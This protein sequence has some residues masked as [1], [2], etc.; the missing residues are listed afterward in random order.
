M[1]TSAIAQALS[2]YFEVDA[3]QIESNL[4][5]DTKIILHDVRLV[6]Q[7]SSIPKNT[8]GTSTKICVTGIVSEVAFTWSWSISGGRSWVKDAILTIKGCSVNVQLTQEVCVSV[9]EDQQEGNEKGFDDDDWSKLHSEADNGTSKDIKKHGGMYAYLQNQMEMIL[10]AL[11]LVIDDYEMTVEMPSP[12]LATGIATCDRQSAQGNSI[13]SDALPTTVDA[14]KNDDDT[15]SIVIGGRKIEIITHGRFYDHEEN[16]NLKEEISIQSFFVNIVETIQDKHGDDTTTPKKK[17]YPLLDPFSYGIESTRTHGKRFSGIGRG[18]VVKGGERFESIL[19]PNQMLSFHLAR[20]QIEAFGKLSG[21][22]L[23][24]RKDTTEEQENKKHESKRGKAHESNIK[25]ADT[26]KN[27]AELGDVSSFYFPIDSVSVDTMGYTVAVTGVSVH[28]MADGADL[29]AKADYFH[30]TEALSEHKPC[31]ASVTCSNISG[32]V[33]PS[34]Q[35]TIGSVSKVNI[36]HVFKLREKMENVKIL[37]IGEVWT[38]QIDSLYGSLPETVEDMSSAQTLETI[39]KNNLNVSDTGS[40]MDTSNGWVAPFPI[41]CKCN[42][43]HLVKGDDEDT[44]M[45]VGNIEILMNPEADRSGTGLAISLESMESKLA[46]V[47]KMSTYTIIP[48]DRNTNTFRDLAFAA[49]CVSV[50]TGYSVQDWIEAF[51]VRGNGSSKESTVFNV[52][53]VT[54]APLKIR[55]TC[56][57]LSVASVGETT[58]LVKAYKGK[59]NTTTNDLTKFYAHQCLNRIPNFVC[60]AEVLGINIKDAG[61]FSLGTVFAF[62]TPIGPFIAVAAVVGVHSVQGAIEAGKRSRKAKEGEQGNV[63]DFFRGIGYA[64]TE[65]TE[66]GKLR[67]GCADDKGNIFDLVV[68]ASESTGGYLNENKDKL[69]SAG[70]AGA[71]MIVGTLLG[72]PIGAVIGGVVGGMSTG[73]TIRKVDKFVKKREKNREKKESTHKNKK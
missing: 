66:K 35:M 18:L 48:A 31:G 37:L 20:P 38:F 6:P 40:D 33:R 64:A 49:E 29:S 2:E 8:Y 59:K 30:Y 51:Q 34:I 11:T 23:A 46:S 7:L 25:N 42:D 4:L 39:P 60:N 32:T 54:V 16:K 57:A 63:V 41:S 70:G 21:L 19:I 27:V 5:S 15:V 26:D 69:G 73:T 1:I 52:P 53:F 71:G 58:F 17:M 13:D 12:T 14:I 36:P 3:N 55:I 72:G 61:A 9:E 45:V 56:S 22:V 43:I 68:G 24:P 62:A 65:A 28:Y 10:D 67:R 47:T 50:T 44:E